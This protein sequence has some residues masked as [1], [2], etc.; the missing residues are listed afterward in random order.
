MTSIIDKIYRGLC[1]II[2]VFLSLT[3]L[4]V[5]INTFLRYT[6]KSSIISSEELSRFLFIWTIFCGGIVAMA[7][8]IHIRV[9]LV[10]A[11]LPKSVN[12]ILS[13]AVNLIL[14]VISAVLAYGGYV[15]TSINLTNYAPATYVPMGYV[16]SV[17]ILSGSGM[18][19]ICLV[20]AV[21]PFLSTG[22]KGGES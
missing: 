13:A 17:V 20:R 6:F 2:V 18:C 1:L 16:Y 3:T 19:L 8:D 4:M 10:T 11:I 7:D 14:A 15:Q 21:R 5:F 12:R 22:A 9:D